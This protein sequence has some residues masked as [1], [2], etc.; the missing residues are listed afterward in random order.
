MAGPGRP[1]SALLTEERPPNFVLTLSFR[2]ERVG[3]CAGV[4]YPLPM[5]TLTQLHVYPVKSLGG[6]SL[7][8]SD[9]CAR[10]LRHDRRW[11]VVDPNA[12]FLTQ[13][14]YP[15][16]AL[17]RPGLTDDALTLDAPGMPT[18][19]VP[20]TPPQA[21]FLTVRVWRSVCEA[22]PV[23]AEADGWLSKY[24]G[25]PAR[26]VWMP[27]TTRRAVNPDYSQPGDVVSFADGY[28]FLLLGEASLEDL[29]ARLAVPVPMDRFR[30]NFVVSGSPAYAEDGW[31]RV[32]IGSVSFRA[33]K[34][35][36]RCGMTAI[37][38][39][40]AARGTEP[41]HTLSGYRMVEKKVLFGQ[42]LIAEGGGDVRVGDGVS[43]L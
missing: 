15:R 32:Q 21:N 34:P 40:T 5:P 24:L 29:N 12:R 43:P 36:D 30:P 27:D 28:P 19:P 6:I 38:Q 18:L 22:L 31:A 11:M 25:T 17:I 20:F 26:L 35:C 39:Q 23:G 14:E 2:K 42:Y 4:R 13:R 1:K 10:G 16:M 3:A 7:T 41:F 9:V 8:Q 37:D 33:A